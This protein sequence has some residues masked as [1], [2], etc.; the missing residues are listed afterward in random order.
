MPPSPNERHPA[1]GERRQRPLRAWPRAHARPPA[2]PFSPGGAVLLLD[3]M[4]AGAG[5]PPSPVLLA[6]D[7]YVEMIKTAQSVANRYGLTREE[8][9][10]FAL[11]S[12]RRAAAA[13]GS[14]RRAA[15][16]HPLEI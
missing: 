13:R 12:R 3:A 11:R 7:A 14:G 5:G 8:S 16:I 15:E 6:R 2:A 1:R 10:A 4:W 9:D